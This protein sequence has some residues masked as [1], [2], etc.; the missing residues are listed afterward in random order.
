MNTLTSSFWLLLEMTVLIRFPWLVQA[1]LRIVVSK[2]DLMLYSVLQNSLLQ[3]IP[4][5]KVVYA[6]KLTRTCLTVSVGASYSE[7]MSSD[8]VMRLAG[9]RCMHACVCVCVCVCLIE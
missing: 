9:R 8:K 3:H 2:C 1:L 6:H 5:I 4:R 7:M